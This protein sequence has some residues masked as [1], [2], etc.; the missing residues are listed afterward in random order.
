MGEGNNNLGQVAGFWIDGDGKSRGFIAT[1][2]LDPVNQS[3][4]GVYTFS[5]AV[6]VDVPIFIDPLV[7]VGYDYKIGAGDPFFK[8]VSLPVGI[9]DNR[10]LITVGDQSF[11]VGGNQIFDFT[12]HGFVT[13]V[14]AFQVSGIEPS[15]ML[16]PADATAFVTRLTFVGSGNFTGS[17][18]ALTF[19]YVAG[20]PEPGA[21]ML[22]LAGIAGLAGFT[23][24][25]MR[26]SV[27]PRGT[28]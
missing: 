1:P 24:R 4:A 6:V 13:G 28:S 18:T 26:R 27:T 19:D 12:A 5:T 17:Q 22:M 25:R 11:E 16:D 15:A 21:A 10:Y 20:V 14:D 23:R 2:A 7:A 9:G 8:S 3:V